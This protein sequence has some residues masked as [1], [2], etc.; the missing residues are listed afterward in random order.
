MV[1][2]NI[3]KEYTINAHFF[4]FSSKPIT[5]Y[6][7]DNNA[8]GYVRRFYTSFRQGLGA[9]L[10]MGNKSTVSNI[11]VKD[12][13]N[14]KKI[15]IVQTE[16]IYIGRKKWKLTL[17]NDK[18]TSMTLYDRSK[19]TLY[20]KYYIELEEG[21]SM[22]IIDEHMGF[23][24]RFMD[25]DNKLLAEAYKKSPASLELKIKIYSAS[26]DIYSIIAF[27]YNTFLATG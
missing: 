6:D 14:K 5:I 21:E 22:W 1:D 19:I 20:P 24:L 17:Y 15:E 4:R 3:V 27:T 13:N 10:F 26:L 7:E 2:N 18:N 9:T 11:E 8:I 23:Q 25:G 16:G 12:I